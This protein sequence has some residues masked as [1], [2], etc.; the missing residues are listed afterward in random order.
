MLQ[1]VTLLCY[2][3]EVN[4]MKQKL[5]NEY[6]IDLAEQNFTTMHYKIMLILLTGKSYTQVQIAEMLGVKHRQNLTVPIKELVE[7]GYVTIDC[8][9]G[10]NKYLKAITSRKKR[11]ETEVSNG[12]LTF[13]EYKEQK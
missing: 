2:N 13:E 10:R 4:K 12:Q 1:Y 7:Q 8:I 9:K 11:L 6:L 3:K 5:S